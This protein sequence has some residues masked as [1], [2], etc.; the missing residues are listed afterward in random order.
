[1]ALTPGR[2]VLVGFPQDEGVRRN[3]GRPGAA[4]APERIRHWL[5]RTTVWDACSGVDLSVTPLLDLGDV[6]CAGSLEDAQD[7]LGTII[8]AVLQTNAVPI[9]LGGGHETAYGHYLG[10]VK[11]GRPVAIVNLDA[12]LDVRS[13]NKGLGHSGSPFRQAMEHPY[14]PLPG[15]HYLCLGAQPH[16]VSRD[17]VRYVLERGGHIEWR[18]G[19]TAAFLQE[20]ARTCESRFPAEVSLYLTVDADVVQMAD[21]PG[22]SAPNPLGIPGSVAANWLNEMGRQPR[23]A[24]LDLVEVCPPHDR[25]DQSSRWAALALWRFLLGLAVR[26]RAILPN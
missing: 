15:N 5:Y 23:C 6:R 9:V 1:M 16:A 3:G 24:S 2:A 20:F 4:V 17:H 21:M 22:V 19:V 7:A 25:D 11:A 13:C 18:P 14:S 12:H 8:A 26:G 10:Y